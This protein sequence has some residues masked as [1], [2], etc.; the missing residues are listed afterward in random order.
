M[1]TSLLFGLALC[2]AVNTNAQT[3]LPATHRLKAAPIDTSGKH[4][5]LAGYLWTMYFVDVTRDG[6]PDYHAYGFDFY[7]EA[8]KEGFPTFAVTWPGGW[9]YSYEGGTLTLLPIGTTREDLT[10]SVTTEDLRARNE[11]KYAADQ[12]VEVCGTKHEVLSRLLPNSSAPFPKLSI[13][14]PESVQIEFY[15]G[16]FNSPGGHDQ[17]PQNMIMATLD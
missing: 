6:A 1:K 4:L 2:L 8:K 11:A 15:S 5:H 14:A 16:Q 17:G 12:G 13:V 9:D 10:T 7:L 3:D